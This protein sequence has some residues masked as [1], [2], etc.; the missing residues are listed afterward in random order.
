MTP[1][2]GSITIPMTGPNIRTH[3]TE[4]GFSQGLEKGG[5]VRFFLRRQADREAAIVELHHVLQR[6][7]RTV[8]KIWGAR[9]Q[10]AQYRPLELADI[11]A[12]AAD[13]RPPQIGHVEGLSAERTAR[14]LNVKRR[15]S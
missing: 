5:Q 2:S 10:S 11:G 9:R 7:R 3:W 14:A 1:A 6:R 13:H 4:A 8:V 12:S 15:Q